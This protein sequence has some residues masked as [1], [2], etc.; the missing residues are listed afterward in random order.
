MSLVTLLVP[1]ALAIVLAA[2]VTATLVTFLAILVAFSTFTLLLVPTGQISK[3]VTEQSFSDE[4]AIQYQ[5][6]AEETGLDLELDE[7]LEPGEEPELSDGIDLDLEKKLAAFQT[8]EAVDNQE[9]AV[10]QWM[11]RFV[12]EECDW[13]EGA[14]PVEFAAGQ[15][16]AN[17][18]L[19]FWPPFSA[20]P[21]LECRL[22]HEQAIR[23]KVSALHAYGARIEAKRSTDLDSQMNVELSFEASAPLRK[24]DAA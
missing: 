7:E 14:I 21:E 9:E 6:V 16:Q 4:S 23:F 10:T 1:V 5:T 8:V 13:I 18:H 24:S 3:A 11:K 17:V 22:E 12:Q 20:A 2:E 15:K 19:T